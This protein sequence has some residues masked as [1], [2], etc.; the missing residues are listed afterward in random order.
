M[1]IKKKILILF[2][3]A[4]V[5]VMP[6]VIYQYSYAPEKDCRDLIQQPEQLIEGVPFS[7]IGGAIN[8][9]SCL[10]N[11]AVFGVVRIR[12]IEDIQNAVLYARK[13]NVKIAVAGARHSMGGQAFAPNALILDML[14]FKQV[15]VDKE[16]KIMVAQ[17]GALWHEIQYLLH[18]E[19]LA[20]QAMQSSSIFTVGGSIS[21][22]AHGMDFRVGSVGSSIRSMR[23]VDFEGNLKTLSKTQ[24]PELFKAVIGGYGLFGI[25]VDAEIQLADNVMY[26]GIRKVIHTQDLLSYFEQEIQPDSL[27]ELFY[28]HL[29]TESR[30]FLDQAI[31]YSFKKITSYQGIIPPLKEVEHVNIRRLIFNLSKPSYFGKKFKWFA[32]KYLDR[33]EGLKVCI[34]FS[35]NEQVPCLISRNAAMHDA[36]EYLRNKL[37]SSV[38]ILQEYF[39]PVHKFTSFIKDIR[40]LLKGSGI[41]TLNVSVRVV[42]KEDNVLSYADQTMFA[43]VVYLNQKTSPQGT[44]LMKNLTVKLIT[45]ALAHQGTFF[46]PYQLYYDKDQLLKAYP[47]IEH[48]FDLKKKYDPSGLFTNYFYEKYAK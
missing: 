9:V 10:N 18:A 4:V 8:D 30:T 29:S 37:H 28:A 41:T 23:I 36:V 15:T 19:Q 16:K 46:L 20:V 27:Y 11:T 13:H 40:P 22:N 12:T 6:Y 44:Q 39:I 26:Q 5:L 21:V 38:D 14:D 24:D 34:P 35:Q 31:I 7:Q 42:H 45:S 3:V 17:S 48:F 2:G 47:H 32:E 33:E 25:I 43:V 1:N